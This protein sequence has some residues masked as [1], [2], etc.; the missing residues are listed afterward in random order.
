MLFIKLGTL[1]FTSE[2]QDRTVLEPNQGQAV[3]EEFSL[4][5]RSI[6]KEVQRGRVFFSSRRIQTELKYGRLRGIIAGQVLKTFRI[7][8]GCHWQETSKLF[9]WVEIFALDVK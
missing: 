1:K 3:F 9:H 7:N 5:V 6:Q 2:K 8:F 4:S